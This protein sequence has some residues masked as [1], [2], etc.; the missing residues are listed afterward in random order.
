VIRIRLARFIGGGLSRE[1]K[2]HVFRFSHNSRLLTICAQTKE[3]QPVILDDEAAAPSSRLDQ[4]AQ[5]IAGK[6]FHATAGG[7]DQLVFMTLGSAQ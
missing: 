7:A 4:G 6:I 5:I 2:A 1:L 3:L